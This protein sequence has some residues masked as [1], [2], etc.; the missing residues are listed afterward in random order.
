M[1]RHFT[2]E[3]EKM[4]NMR[5]KIFPTSLTMEEM[6]IKIMISYY[7]ITIRMGK[8]KNSD[9]GLGWCSKM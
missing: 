1:K 9:T 8:I 3:D 2:T 4:A 6:H 7:Y 5:I